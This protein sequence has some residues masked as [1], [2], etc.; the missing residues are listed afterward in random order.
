MTPSG[1]LFTA[2][3]SSRLQPHTPSYA[4]NGHHN[5]PPSMTHT[6]RCHKNSAPSA[7]DRS[8]RDPSYSCRVALVAHSRRFYVRRQQSRSNVVV[9]KGT[10]TTDLE[11]LLRVGGLV[12]RYQVVNW[13]P[14]QT[15]GLNSHAHFNAKWS[16]TSGPV[17]LRAA[18]DGDSHACA[19]RLASCAGSL[20]AFPSIASAPL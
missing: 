6:K 14:P 4:F 11:T 2:C 15:S 7:A 20:I 19:D 3:A 5:H 1:R 9:A 10:N 12:R 17:V 8:C 16:M 13:Q 18:T